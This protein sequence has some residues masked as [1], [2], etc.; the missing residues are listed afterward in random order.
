MNVQSATKQ[1]LSIENIKK[2]VQIHYGIDVSIGKIMELSEGY[3][4]TAYSIE[5]LDFD[6]DIV[7]K[8]APIDNLH[9]L[10]YE[11]HGIETEIKILQMLQNKLKHLLIPS[12]KLIT[13]D[14]TCSKIDLK[15]FIVEKFTGKSWKSLKKTLSDKE[16]GSIQKSLGYI[17]KQ[18]NSIQNSH[19]GPIFDP[20][21]PDEFKLKTLSWS[22]TFKGLMDNLFIDSE[23][24]GVKIPVNHEK[25][26]QI[27]AKLILP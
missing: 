10:T 3:Y 25:M 16:K 12:P 2:V 22:R 6:F 8:A 23:R 26:D 11:F 9:Q 19:F 1:I 17:Q 24:F 4:S 5:L 27:L 18:L 14:L 15:Y 20:N 7:L 13:F 21:H